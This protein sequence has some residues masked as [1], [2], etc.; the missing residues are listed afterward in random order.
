MDSKGVCHIKENK[1]ILPKNKHHIL[2]SILS[3]LKFLFQDSKL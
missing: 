1:L 3:H 2:M